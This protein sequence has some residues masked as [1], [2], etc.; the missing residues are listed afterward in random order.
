MKTFPLLNWNSITRKLTMNYEKTTKSMENFQF[1]IGKFIFVFIQM[2]NSFMKLIMKFNKL[3]YQ[4]VMLMLMLGQ[5]PCGD[6]QIKHIFNNE[7][8]YNV[9]KILTEIFPCLNL[10]ALLEAFELRVFIQLMEI[11]YGIWF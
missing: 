7:S 8:V 11:F 5:T 6:F 2:T 9:W 3:W 10:L 4:T 1:P